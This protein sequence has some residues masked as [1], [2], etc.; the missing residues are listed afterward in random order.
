MKLEQNPAISLLVCPGCAPAGRADAVCARCKGMY[1][2]MYDEGQFLYWGL[3]LTAEAIALRHAKQ[4]VG[5]IVNFIALLFGAG[6]LLLLFWNVRESPLLVFESDFWMT[7]GAAVAWFWIGMLAWLYLFMRLLR[8]ATRQVPISTPDFWEENEAQRRR[9]AAAVPSIAPWSP[10]APAVKRVDIAKSVS[11]DVVLATE[12]A[13]HLAH[14]IDAMDVDVPHLL[15]A[16]V[17]FPEIQGIFVRLGVAHTTLNSFAAQL[18][19]ANTAR[20]RTPIFSEH[21]VQVVFHAYF[22]AKKSGQPLVGLGDLLLAVYRE[23]E[24]L[25]TFLYDAGVDARQMN[26][27]VAWVRI[28]AQLREDWYRRRAA[29]K[30]RPKGDTNRAMTALATPYLDSF[31][32]DLTRQ[33]AYGHLQPLIGRETEL[34]ALFRALQGSNRSV[35]LVGEEGVGKEAM[36]DGLAWRMVEDRVPP[37]LYDKRLM[38]LSPGRLLAG[39]TPAQAQERLLHMLYEARRAGNIIL[40]IPSIHTIIGISEGGDGSLDVASVLARELE[41][42]GTFVVATTT[43]ES[44]RRY[45]ASTSIANSFTK[46]EIAEMAVDQAIRVLE[47]K[48]GFIEYQHKIWYSYAALETA[49][50]LTGRFIHDDRLPN[51][52]IVVLKEVAEAVRSQR[53]EDALVTAQDVAKIVSEK[54]KIPV[55]AVTEDESAKLLR[56]EEELHQRVI[57]QEEAVRAVSSALRRARVQLGSGK[58]TIANFLFM[59]PTGVGKTELA[60]TVAQVYFGGESQMIR[61]DMSEFQDPTSLTRLIGAPNVKGSGILTEAIRQKPYAL[62]LLDEL[63]KADPNVLNLF[64]QVMDDGRITDSMGVTI[65]CTNIILI[66]TSNAGTSYVQEQLKAGTDYMVIQENL[67]HG[68]LGQW[69]RPE[70]LNRFDAIVLFRALAQE[71]IAKIARL[72]VESIG[73]RLEEQGMGLAVDEDVVAYLAGAGFDPQFGARP[74]R[75]VIQDRVENTIAELLLAKKIHRGQMIHF[76]SKGVLVEEHMNA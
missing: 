2:G 57:G 59:G 45:V 7:G 68:V 65:D 69:F 46:I 27:V 24:P 32:D 51:K 11:P 63:E 60:K 33:A 41:Q 66:A 35:L 58:R 47:A 18:S 28:R 38:V 19:H 52:A 37:V 4:K 12:R 30:R 39:A 3:A 29:A 14:S 1:S 21:A 49:A 54:S 10:G 22:E 70:F 73:R 44:Y 26:N 48:A 53:G 75:R 72:M 23:N 50:E 25:Q 71:E 5:R 56:L 31:T 43:P 15:A 34:N 67:L 17:S 36:V 76:T 9:E 40:F 8:N 13:Y 16:L 42:G 62:L 64:L 20:G 55:T 6:G 61:L 74:M